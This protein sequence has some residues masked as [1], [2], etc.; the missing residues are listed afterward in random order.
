MVHRLQNAKVREISHQRRRRLPTI[1]ARLGG[2]AG[3][4]SGGAAGRDGA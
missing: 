3:G 2:F 1:S 4:I